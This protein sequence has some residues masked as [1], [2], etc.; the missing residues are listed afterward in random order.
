MVMGK[1][2]RYQVGRWTRLA[3][4]DKLLARKLEREDGRG[5]APTQ[6]GR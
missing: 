5:R 2:H 3:S 4:V 6:A 1:E